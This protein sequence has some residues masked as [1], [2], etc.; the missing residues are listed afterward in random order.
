MLLL[1]T[2]LLTLLLTWITRRLPLLGT[3]KSFL[4]P[5]RRKILP[6]LRGGKILLRLRGRKILLLLRRGEILLLL[7]KGI[8]LLPRRSH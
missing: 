8:L 4:L 5:R 6:L 1:R 3:W 7:R 2:T